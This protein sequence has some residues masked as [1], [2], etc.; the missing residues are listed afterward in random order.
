MSLE[1][2]PTADAAAAGDPGDGPAGDPSHDGQQEQDDIGSLWA[3]ERRPLVVGLVLTITLV[4]FE[5]LAIATVMPD[6]KNEIGGLGLYGWVFSGFVLS[7]LI[8]IVIA[9]QLVDRRGLLPP[10]A[11]GLGVFAVGLVVGGAAQSMPMLIAGRCL[12]GFGAG[13]IPATAYA[14]IARGIPGPLR[15]RMFAVTSTAWVVPGLIGPT[16]AIAIEHAW[17]WRAVFLV[18]VP[19]VAVAGAITAPALRSLGTAP[20]A[21][22]A[23]PAAAVARRRADR[24]CVLQ[25]VALVL[26]VAAVF[27]AVTGPP[28]PVALALVAVGAPVVGWCLVR[29]LPD[30]TVRLA[31]GVPA[32]V[33]LRGIL[34]FAFFSAD[35]FVPLAIEDGRGG[36]K[37]IVGA[38][39]TLCTMLWTAGSWTQERWIARVGPRRLDQIGFALLAASVALLVVMAQGAPP[40]LAIV[41]WGAG[42]YAIG[43]AY[44]PQAVTVLAAAA[45]GEEGAAS[46]AIQFSDAFGFAVGTA[47]AGAVI[48]T[49]DDLGWSVADGTTIVF[50]IAAAVALVGLVSS[51]RLPAKVP[52]PAS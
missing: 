24:D 1:P 36:D 18:L 45:P 41:A 3:P 29:I 52:A 28:L 10:Y 4:A 40:W 51:R 21:E 22:D 16:A 50:V 7:S 30:G 8:G 48:A 17:S 11:A 34:T 25:V 15:P 31:P 38:A 6:V 23:D 9:G 19:I 46:S 42:G 47:L 5:A 20:T 39:L 37:W 2:P 44:A 26:G 27:A 14:A 43:I 13:A 32:T 49:A 12:Q 33:G 35:T